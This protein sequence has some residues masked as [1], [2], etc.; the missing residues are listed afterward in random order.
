MK[1]M[2]YTDG[3]PNAAKA[4]QFAAHFKKHL[5]ADLAVLTVRPGTHAGEEPPPIGVEFDLTDQA[6]L[7]EG[8]KTLI[9]AADILAG[10]SVVE[11]P[12]KVT[13]QDMAKGYMFV[14]KTADGERVPFYESFGHF[15]EALNREVDDHDYDLLIIAPPMRSRL[16]RLVIGDT[17]RKL[18]LD[19]HT[20]VLFVRGGGPQGRYLVCAD[21]SPAS[22]RQFPLLRQ[23]LPA[24]DPPVDLICVQTPNQADDA[25]QAARTCL[26]RARLWL[27]ACGKQGQMGITREQSRATAI[28]AAAGAQSI[29]MMGASLRHD[30]Y[31]RMRGSL[32]MQILDRTASSVML[33]K[34]PPEA[35]VDYSKMPFTCE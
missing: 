19:L 10:L 18:A 25:A 4:L 1:I 33:A 26:E 34:H 31:K 30:V 2:A 20:S 21:G 17:P 11:L 27:G 29:I 24:I 12:E 9:R 13:F 3:G 6:V 8:L 5:K 23:I 7:P 15:I 22:H 35:D 28:L 32:P 16:G 14:C